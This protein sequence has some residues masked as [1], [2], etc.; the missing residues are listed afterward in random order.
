MSRMLWNVVLCCMMFCYFACCFCEQERPSLCHVPC[1][2]SIS[3]VH[4]WC[5]L[6]C[7]GAGNQSQT[8]KAMIII[9]FRIHTS[10]TQATVA[11]SSG[12]AEL[13]A[14]GQGTSE[15]LLLK[16]LIVCKTVNMIVYT[17]STAGRSVAIR[18]AGKKT[19]HVELR[20][21]TCRIWCALA[22]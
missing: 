19:K 3:V 5:A 18:F 13:Y 1:I 4:E 15:A 17:D 16:S 7:R 6:L 12:E 22:C 20:C 21:C 11:L 10:R 2:T 8:H 9:F 14:M